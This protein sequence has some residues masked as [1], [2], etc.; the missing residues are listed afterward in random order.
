[1]PNRLN[2][3]AIHPDLKTSD[4]NPNCIILRCPPYVVLIP[5][6]ARHRII[7]RN[8]Q[9]DAKTATFILQISNET[10]H[11]RGPVHPPM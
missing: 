7:A 4:L 10:G 8:V 9:I 2:S 11:D 1:M 5:K 3:K 6:F